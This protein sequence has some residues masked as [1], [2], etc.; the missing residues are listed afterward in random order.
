MPTA[1]KE[2]E[3]V[4]ALAGLGTWANRPSA[5]LNV[6][7]TKNVRRTKPADLSSVSKSVMGVAVLMQSVD[8]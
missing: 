8:Q 3:C 4:S 2:M 6:Q 5:D 7:S 1:R